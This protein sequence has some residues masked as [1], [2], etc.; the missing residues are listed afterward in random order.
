MARE[1]L[2]FTKSREAVGKDE[3]HACSRGKRPGGCWQ[4]DQMRG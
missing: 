3:L 4:C 2:I 1:C